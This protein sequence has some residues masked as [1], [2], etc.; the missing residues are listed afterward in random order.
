V[1]TNESNFAFICFHLLF[2][3]RAFQRVTADSNKKFASTGVRAA[4]CER[5][6]QTA[7]VSPIAAGWTAVLDS[8]NRDIMSAYFC[9]VKVILG[10]SKH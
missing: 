1:K 9:F 3:I 10:F 5:G 6:V 8:D 2:R 7:T 4:G